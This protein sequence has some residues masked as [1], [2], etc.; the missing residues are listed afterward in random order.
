MATGNELIIATFLSSEHVLMEATA[1]MW[2]EIL[3]PAEV[4]LLATNLTPI[5]LCAPMAL[6]AAL[7]LIT[8][9]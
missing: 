2:Y 7:N 6:K 3:K 8:V 4:W 5:P 9:A 1:K